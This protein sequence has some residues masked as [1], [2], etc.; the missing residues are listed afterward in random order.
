MRKNCVILASILKVTKDAEKIDVD[1]PILPRQR[2]R[3]IK[4]QAT[5][6]LKPQ[7]STVQEYFKESYCQAIE[8]MVENIKSRFEQ[9]GYQIYMKY[10]YKFIRSLVDNRT[11]PSSNGE[12][13]SIGSWESG[14]STFVKSA[15][16]T[17]WHG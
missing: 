9:K 11:Y 8:T 6:G 4:M 12:H 7:F 3:T 1:E 16:A 5:E 10:C 14:S 2:R 13:E 17:N 15:T